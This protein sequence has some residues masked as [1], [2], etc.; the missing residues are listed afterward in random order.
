[1]QAYR[2]ECLKWH[3]IRKGSNSKEQV[4]DVRWIFEDEESSRKA[5]EDEDFIEDVLELEVGVA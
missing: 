3:Y 2:A 5:F 4:F 1:M